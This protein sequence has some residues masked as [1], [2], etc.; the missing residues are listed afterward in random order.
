MRL[1]WRCN[2][3]DADMA[4]NI[5]TATPESSRYVVACVG[6]PSAA[7]TGIDPGVCAEHRPGPQYQQDDRPTANRHGPLERR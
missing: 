3:R 2:S 6:T 1:T 4:P 7:H 5:G